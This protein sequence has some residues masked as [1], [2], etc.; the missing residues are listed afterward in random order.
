MVTSLDNE[1]GE[2]QNFAV[3]VEDDVIK[4]KVASIV[5]EKEFGRLMDI[6][7]RV[8]NEN[9]TSLVLF[10]F[11]KVENFSLKTRAIWVQFLKNSQIKKV[12]IFGCGHFI[13]V[14]ISFVI[15]TVNKKNV[16]VFIN[17]EEALA[18][19]KS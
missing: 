15:K 3:V 7:T 6:G 2:D 14:A 8:V 5:D 11:S 18:W 4:Y 17:E 1:K 16:C 9:I 10:D 19:F 13:K 12:A